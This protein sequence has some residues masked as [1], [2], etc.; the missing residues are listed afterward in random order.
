[1]KKNTEKNTEKKNKETSSSK[2][3]EPDLK[4]EH[5][6]EPEFGKVT[7]AENLLKSIRDDHSQIRIN[8]ESMLTL[9]DPNDKVRVFND[10]VKL[11]SRHGT[12]EEVIL[13]PT[14]KN[15]GLGYLADSAIEQTKYMEKLLREMDKSY[16]KSIDDVA[17]FH[18]D[19]IRLRDAFNNHAGLLEETEM[20]PVLESKL[21]KDDIDS[22]NKWFDRIKAI[23][24]TRPHPSSPHS[25]TGQLFTGPVLA[26]VDRFR[27]LSKK[28]S[29]NQ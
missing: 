29:K 22:I 17:Q 12:A 4:I 15:L 10:T 14:V 23:A 28:F 27:D 24:P 6:T 9:E 2:E 25:A 11:F 16:G 3:S 21:S 13:Y 20:L 26:F 18:Q 5:I 1:M 8:F 19:L 7:H